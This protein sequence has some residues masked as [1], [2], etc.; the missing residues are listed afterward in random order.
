MERKKNSG[1]NS[2]VKKVQTEIKK[3]KDKLNKLMAEEER[4][5]VQYQTESYEETLAYLKS[6][7]KNGKP[8]LE[9]MWKFLQSTYSPELKNS[10]SPSTENSAH[11]EESTDDVEENSET[12]EISSTVP[13]Q[14]FLIMIQM[15]LSFQLTNFFAG[16]PFGVRT[17]CFSN[18]I[19][20]ANGKQK[21]SFQ[22][23]QSR[24]DFK[25]ERF[26]E[27]GFANR[28]DFFLKQ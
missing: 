3:T 23:E 24:I 7:S 28:T 15:I 4:L 22:C 10:V 1:N 8:D 25:I 13:E 12:E 19:E 27:Y 26:N 16:H 9:E 20:V 2:K 18:R 17:S 14:K 5:T 6:A 21:L 11:S